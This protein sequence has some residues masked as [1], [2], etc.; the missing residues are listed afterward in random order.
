MVSIIFLFLT[1]FSVHLVL[2]QTF[3]IQPKPFH[4]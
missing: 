1:K 4:S 2:W 3:H